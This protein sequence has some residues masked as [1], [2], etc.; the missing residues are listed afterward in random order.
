[1][2]YSEK[3][4]RHLKTGYEPERNC[5]NYSIELTTEQVIDM[6]Q[7][8]PKKSNVLSRISK[9]LHQNARCQLPL[10]SNLVKE[11]HANIS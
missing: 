1:M 10:S 7:Q 2:R 8:M 6:V 3:N 9:L 11:K 5:P 4:Q